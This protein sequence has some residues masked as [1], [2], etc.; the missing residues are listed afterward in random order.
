MDEEKLVRD[1]EG[2]LERVL[3]SKIVVE[4]ETHR[5]HHDF[6]ALEIERREERRKMFDRFRLSIIG[7]IAMAIVGALIWVGKVVAEHVLGRVH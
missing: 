7:G 1:I 3:S 2:A 6:I 4:A 5:V